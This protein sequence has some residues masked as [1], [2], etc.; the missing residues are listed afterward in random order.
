LIQ[1]TPVYPVEDKIPRDLLMD[2]FGRVKLFRIIFDF[3]NRSPGFAEG[4]CVP[5]LYLWT[6]G[7]LF[8]SYS[9]F[10]TGDCMIRK[11]G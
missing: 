4:P 1:D 7:Y 3:L 11:T 8:L 6:G 2:V 9:P 10:N 5:W